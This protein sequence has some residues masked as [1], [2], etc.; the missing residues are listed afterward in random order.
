MSGPIFIVGPMGSGTTLLRLVLDSHDHIG[1][2]PETG[3]MRGYGALR[4]TPFKWSGGDWTGRLGWS[5]EE[6]DAL[7]RDFYDRLFM[8]YAEQHGKRRWGEKTPL[9][10]W[11][12][13][14]MARVF[15]D[16]QF[17]GV[18][19]HP[20]GTIA[21]NMTR[22]K[23]KLARATWQW[24]QP[25]KELVR[26]ADRL[27]GRF[28]IVRYEEL[29]RQPEPVLREL[30]EWLGEPWSPAVLEHHAVQGGR[31]GPSRVEGR[32]RADDPIDETRVAKWTTAM[33]EEHRD[34]LSERVGPL[35]GF[36][37]YA[38]DDPQA[39]EP[40]G[41]NGS[42]LLRAPELTE[43]IDRH[44]AL[45]LRKGGSGGPYDEPYDPRELMVLRRKEYAWITRPRGLRRTGIA[46]VRALPFAP[47]RRAVV[48]GVRGARGALGLTRRHRAFRR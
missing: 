19:R 10:T 6:V 42:A 14:D 28:V 35:A 48:K 4:F 29:V 40:G 20:F 43:R 3:F 47:A 44:P 36:F 27:P 22:F 39:L 11:H 1:I 2:P 34:W 24:A 30:L 8:R 5:E 25:A 21:S 46:V 41:A 45:E 32:S 17:I 38:L 16:A 9:H 37:G 31:G 33:L 15:P 23:S 18:V 7:A 12:V 26:Q 13:D